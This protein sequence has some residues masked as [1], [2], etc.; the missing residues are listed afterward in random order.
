MKKFTENFSFKKMLAI[1]VLFGALFGSLSIYTIPVNAWDEPET[2]TWTCAGSDTCNASGSCSTP[3]GEATP[4]CSG[5]T[6]KGNR[7]C[8]TSCV[9]SN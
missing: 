3:Q 2:G 1:S 6:I 7:P 5:T 4:I 8:A 9:K